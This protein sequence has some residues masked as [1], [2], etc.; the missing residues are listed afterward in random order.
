MAPAKIVSQKTYPIAGKLSVTEH[1]FDCVKDYR[2]PEDGTIRIFARSVK[3]HETPIVAEKPKDNEQPP[4]MLYLQGGPGMYCRSPQHYPW[5]QTILEKGYQMLFLDQRGTGLS[6]PITASTLQMRGNSDEQARYLKLFR[7]D[8]IVKDAEAIRLALTAKCAE[9]TKRW[10]I[11]GQS[12]GGFCSIS[13]LSFHPEGLR[14]AF[15][16]GGLQPLVKSPDDVYRRLYKKVIRRNEAYYAKYPDDVARVRSIVSHL[17]SPKGGEAKLSSEDRLTR[18]RFRQLGIAFGAHGG[19]D[20]VHDIVL[21]AANDIEMFGHLTR[22]TL[23]VIEGGT[24]F[25]DHLLYAILHEPIYCEGHAP[26]WSAQ[27]L[28]RDEYASAFDVDKPEYDGP[29][30]FTGE[31][32]FP[33]MFEDHSEL[34]KVQDV[35]NKIA[36]DSEWGALFNE[37]KLASNDVPIASDSEWGALFNE[38]KLASNDVPVYAA[39]YTEDMYVDF[40]LSMET[41]RKIKGCKVFSTNVFFH[42]AI[43]SKMDDVV[44]AAFTLRDDV[45]D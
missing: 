23:S 34:R 24:S 3:K 42:D 7:A 29:V 10:T 4:W 6:T 43:R 12:F 33:W 31:M 25:D 21:R 39:A 19:L 9:E 20:A 22:G 37:E 5:T 40:D 45:I 15:L 26:N 18:R 8:T 32:I 17:K 11:M 30:Y 16:F 28:Q 1:L 38:E 27:R 35:A 36:S 2:K 41:A 14:E 13:Y 44:K